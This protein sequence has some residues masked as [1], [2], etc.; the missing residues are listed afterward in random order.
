MRE[1][2]NLRVMFSST[3]K[4]K[5]DLE[6]HL[7]PYTVI[8]PE[9]SGV[10]GKLSRMYDDEVDAYVYPNTGMEYWDVAAPEAIFR[11]NFGASHACF[12]ENFSYDPEVSSKL[13]CPGA[14]FAK[15][16]QVLDLVLRRLA[17]ILK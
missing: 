5:E 8:E 11:G 12:I 2:A 7:Q 10:A 4:N 17:K 3:L 1:D 16:K 14:I 9:S 15:N 6:K 13:G